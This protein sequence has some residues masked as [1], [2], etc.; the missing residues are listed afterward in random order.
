MIAAAVIGGT[1]LAGGTGSI[2]GSALGRADHAVARQR[3]AAARCLDRQADGHHR[4]GADRRGGVRRAVSHGASERSDGDDR[5]SGAAR[6]AA[7]HPQ[8]LR[9]RARRRRRQHQ[10][11]RR[12]GRRAARPQRRRQVDADEDAGRRVSGRFGRHGDRRRDGSHP[13]A[14]GRAVRSASRRSTRRWRS[15]TTSTRWRTCSSA[16]RS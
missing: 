5:A 13:H 2:L 11:V 4:P 16:A 14:G 15:P 10:S 7:R 6:R 1:A 3:D 8:G 12:R 9:R